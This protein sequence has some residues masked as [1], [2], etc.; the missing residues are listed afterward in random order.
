MDTYEIMWI[1]L[2]SIEEVIVHVDNAA[3][4]NNLAEDWE[5]ISGKEVAEG[6]QPCATNPKTECRWRRQRRPAGRSSGAR[7]AVEN[8]CS[9]EAEAKVGPMG[10]RVCLSRLSEGEVRRRAQW[11]GSDLFDCSCSFLIR[12]CSSCNFPVRQRRVA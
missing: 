2:Y 8:A 5:H 10:A 3:T 4:H 6:S 12:T 1:N 9:N 11:D 7:V